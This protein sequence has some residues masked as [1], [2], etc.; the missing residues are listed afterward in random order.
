MEPSAGLW[1]R[2]TERLV[3]EVQQS[4]VIQITAPIL[5][6]I[7][8]PPVSPAETT[9]TDAGESRRTRE[10]RQPNRSCHARHRR[11]GGPTPGG[12]LRRGGGGPETPV[13]QSRPPRAAPPRAARRHG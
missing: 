1:E 5:K 4:T 9:Q 8:R 13:E 7:R 12:R 10:P 2:S 3:K 11:H 6:P